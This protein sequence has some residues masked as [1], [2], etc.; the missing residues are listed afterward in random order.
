MA[1]IRDKL[2]HAE[3]P[4]P[5]QGLGVTLI[6]TGLMAMAFAGFKGI[7]LIK[8]IGEVGSGSGH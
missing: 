2:K 1:G 3:I 8:F 7:N 4:K 6:I 5:L